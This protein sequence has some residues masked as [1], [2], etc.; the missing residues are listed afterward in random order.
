MPLATVVID[1][2]KD[3]EVLLQEMNSGAKNHV[4]KAINK[5]IEFHIADPKDYENFYEQWHK[6]SVMK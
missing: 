2:S 6:V 3:D 5:Q 1:T 4:R